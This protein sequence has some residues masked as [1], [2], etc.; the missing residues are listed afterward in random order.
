[1]ILLDWIEINYAILII[2]LLADLEENSW[3]KGPSTFKVNFE[4]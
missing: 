3:E 2:E 1:M 4:D